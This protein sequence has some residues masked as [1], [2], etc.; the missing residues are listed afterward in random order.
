[1]LPWLTTKPFIGGTLK[2]FLWCRKL[3]EAGRLEAPG[4]CINIICET[5]LK[6]RGHMWRPHWFLLVY[7]LKLPYL[8]SITKGV[9]NGMN[10]KKHPFISKEITDFNFYGSERILTRPGS[11]QHLS[12]LAHVVEQMISNICNWNWFK[13]IVVTQQG[14]YEENVSIVIAASSEIKHKNICNRLFQKANLK[15]KSIFN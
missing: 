1:M 10:I 14:K 11:S 7:L 4:V 2:Y 13:K 6:P 12:L 5:Q 15:V 9:A 8:T 3:W